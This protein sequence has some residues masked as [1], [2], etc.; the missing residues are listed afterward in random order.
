MGKKVDYTLLYR[1]SK[2]Y[3]LDKK[4]QQEIADVENFSRPQISRLLKKALEDELVTYTLNFPNALDEQMLSRQLREQ[5]KLE[6]VILIP[7]FYSNA[8]AVDNHEISKNLALGAAGIL[9]KLLEDAKI[10]GVGW[11][12]S[13]Y[14]ASLHIE[15]QKPLR[16][17]MVLP[18][19]G[20]VGDT[21]PS[22]QINTIVDRFG[23][24]LHAERKYLNLE[25]LQRR[26]VDEGYIQRTAG[27][28][29]CRWKELDA[30]I[31]GIGG[32][33][34]NPKNL[35]SEYPAS[36]KQRIRSSGTV[37]DILSQFLYADGQILEPSPGMR[38]MAYDIRDLPK[39]KNVIALAAG[40]DKVAPIC[41]A[42]QMGYIK[43]LITDY[44][45]ATSILRKGEKSL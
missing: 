31:I 20:S 15:M 33:P 10:I 21:N 19:I 34:A 32:S 28:V 41:V 16:G 40:D 25:T 26:N 6:Q 8:G 2:A 9:P 24:Q 18:L 42:A 44:N 23:E 30:A 36:Y 3:Y 4:T 11:G 1:I 39:V 13:L 14:H 43:T 17:R 7:S 12:R 35:I 22:L 45:T 38:L 29:L 5:L 27:N 37:G